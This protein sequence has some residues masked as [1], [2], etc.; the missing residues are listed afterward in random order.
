MIQ[1]FVGLSLMSLFLFYIEIPAWFILAFDISI[2]ITYYLIVAY[3]ENPTINK[4]SKRA[5]LTIGFCV[6]S[7]AFIGCVIS[8]KVL[9]FFIENTSYLWK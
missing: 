2:I 3:T 7:A 6:G 5:A 4:V 9:L 8:I 1:V